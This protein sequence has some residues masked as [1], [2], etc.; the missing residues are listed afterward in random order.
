MI[1]KSYTLSFFESKLPSMHELGAR[2]SVKH[3][4]TSYAFHREQD[5]SRATGILI[6]SCTDA[7]SIVSSN[8]RV[9]PLQDESSMTPWMHPWLRRR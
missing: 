5:T 2:S 3:H 7:S 4:A 8:P 9:R 6:T 1:I